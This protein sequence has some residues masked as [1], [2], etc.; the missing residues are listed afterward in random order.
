[1]V[2]VFVVC[3][4]QLFEL[5]QTGSDMFTPASHAKANVLE[6]KVCFFSFSQITQKS[7]KLSCQIYLGDLKVHTRTMMFY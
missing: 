6:R 3:L 2:N 7:I 1:M 4:A 5:L